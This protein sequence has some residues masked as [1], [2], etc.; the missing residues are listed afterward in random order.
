MVSKRSKTAAAAKKK[1]SKYVL[2]PRS[3]QRVKVGS[4]THKQLKKEGVKMTATSRLSKSKGCSNERKWERYAEE[5]HLKDSDFCGPAGGTSCKHAYPVFDEAHE[6]AALS[7]AWHAPNPD[8]IRA[9]VAKHRA[10]RLKK[11]KS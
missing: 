1:S 5:H 8:G 9:C 11:M 10:A 7:R 4:A 2:N 6:R 3:G